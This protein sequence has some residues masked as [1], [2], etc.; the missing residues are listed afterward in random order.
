MR[1]FASFRRLAACAAFACT[2][3]ACSD[4][5]TA[6][7][8]ITN[9]AATI[10]DLFAVDSAFDSDAFRALQDLTGFIAQPTAPLPL[11]RLAA[12]LRVTLPPA[13]AASARA[14]LRRDLPRRDARLLGGLVGASSRPPV[15]PD[16]LLGTTFVWEPDSLHYVASSRSGAPLNGIRFVL[17]D[18]D[19]LTSQPDTAAEVGSLDIIDLAPAVGAQLRF[20]VRGVSGSP[21]FLDYT[22]TYL[23][24][25]SAF[26]VGANG[27]LSNGAPGA[28]ERRFTFTAAITATETAGGADG[29]VAFTYDLN[30]PDVTVEL[31]FATSEDTLQDS[32]FLAIDYRFTRRNENIRFVGGDTTTAGN[33]ENGQFVVTVNGH[34]YATLTITGNTGVV[35]DANGD[36][37]PIDDNDQ[38]HED[39]IILILFFGVL[40]STLILGDVLAIPALLLGFSLGLL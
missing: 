1:S 32:S 31:N 10:A 39:T 40:H 17:Y 4:S 14:T 15:L 3:A 2:V 6:P 30:V 26:T 16:S 19:T 37:V 36:V 33:T 8:T 23:A 13:P 29:T 35:T 12:A 38:R 24:G 21:T 25:A 34:L 28:R 11:T 22:L 7:G 9:P 27:F 20:L 18:T 5:P